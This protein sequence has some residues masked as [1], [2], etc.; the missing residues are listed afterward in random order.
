MKQTRW[1]QDEL[2]FLKL[3]YHTMTRN[4]MAITLD[5]SPYAVRHRLYINNILKHEQHRESNTPLYQVWAN[6]KSRCMTTTCHN[7]HYYGGRGITI[8]NEWAKSFIAF[9]KWAMSHGYAN[10]LQIDRI[11]NDGD[12]T[13]DNCR[14]VTSQVNSQNKRNTRLTPDIVKQIRLLASQ[15]VSQS[16]IARRFAIGVPTV[17]NVIHGN[18]WANVA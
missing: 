11:N 1:T 8:C 18:K 16:D 12:Y 4:E 2:T 13:P 17:H 6:M 3:N 9:K 14:W 15:Q 5:R 10:T 7:Y